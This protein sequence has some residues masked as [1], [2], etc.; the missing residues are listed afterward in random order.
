MDPAFAGGRIDLTTSTSTWMRTTSVYSGGSIGGDGGAIFEVTAPVIIDL[1]HKV[2]AAP[3]STLDGPGAAAFYL[4]G[5]D[6]ELIGVDNTYSGETAFYVGPNAAN[7][8]IRDGAVQTAN[9]YPERFLVVRGGA[10]NVTVRNYDVA[11]FAPTTASGDGA[12][13]T[14]P[15]PPPPRSPV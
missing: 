13:S 2:T 15:P 3:V 6:I 9:Y 12:G 11:G 8:T 5:S 7:V 1:E 10:S 4:N 14:A